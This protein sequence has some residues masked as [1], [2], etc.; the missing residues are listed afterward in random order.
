MEKQFYVYIHYTLDNKPFYVGKGKGNRAYH[1]HGRSTWWNRIVFKHG[2]IVEIQ[3]YFLTEEEAFNREK[4]LIVT[5]KENKFELCNLTNGGDGTSGWK[6]SKET[7]EKMS[8]AKINRIISKETLLKATGKNNHQFK[9]DVIAT[10]IKDGSIIVLTGGIHME[11]LGFDKGRISNCITGKRKT[12]K[13]YTF[14]RI[15]L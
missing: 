1:K 12:H 11:S 10:N 7:K 9:G 2:L 4:S 6:H 3:E 14:E 5:L 15:T 8:L 13:G